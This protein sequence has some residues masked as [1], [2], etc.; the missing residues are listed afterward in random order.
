MHNG[1]FM[2]ALVVESVHRLF[3]VKC[4]SIVKRGHRLDGHVLDLVGLHGMI[5][6]RIGVTVLMSGA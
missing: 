4:T 6:V 2:V 3:Y 5:E 1:L